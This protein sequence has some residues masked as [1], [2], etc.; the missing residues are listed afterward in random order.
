MNNYIFAE[1]EFVSKQKSVL[2]YLRDKALCDVYFFFLTGLTS[3]DLSRQTCTFSF[4][5]RS[6]TSEEVPK[7]QSRIFSFCR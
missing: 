4:N 7:F 3:F 6:R 2:I 5:G 1:S